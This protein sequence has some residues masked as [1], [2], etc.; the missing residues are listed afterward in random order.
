MS[1]RGATQT[2]LCN[3]TPLPSSHAYQ[4]R[5]IATW[6]H[7][8]PLIFHSTT[9]HPPSPMSPHLASLTKPHQLSHLHV[10]S[11]PASRFPSPISRFSSHISHLT[12]QNSPLHLATHSSHITAHSLQ[13]PPSPPYLSHPTPPCMQGGLVG[14]RSDPVAVLEETLQVARQFAKEAK[15]LAAVDAAAFWA[16]AQARLPSCARYRCAKSPSH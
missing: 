13:L 12:S 1:R 2:Q 9:S 8:P 5:P 6:N 14:A 10:P 15:Q 3:S 4:S 11:S 16:D 7:L